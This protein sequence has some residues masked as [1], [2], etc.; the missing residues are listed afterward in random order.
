MLMLR[1]KQDNTSAASLDSHHQAHT[2]V[3]RQT[4]RYLPTTP[5]ISPTFL[6]HVVSLQHS[7][8]RMTIM[9]TTTVS[10][11]AVIA[12]PSTCVTDETPLANIEAEP[13]AEATAVTVLEPESHGERDFGHGVDSSTIV[14]GIPTEQPIFSFRF[15][16]T[17]TGNA[18]TVLPTDDHH[19]I[20][21]ITTPETVDLPH[22]FQIQRDNDR[23]TIQVRWMDSSV[24]RLAIFTAL[25][26]CLVE[27]TAVTDGLG[28]F[29]AGIGVLFI[30]I[31]LRKFMNATFVVITHDS[32]ELRARPLNDFMCS[33][34]VRFD[35]SGYEEIRV[36]RTVDTREDRLSVTFELHKWDCRKGTFSILPVYTE[37]M[38]E[39][40][41]VAQEIRR[42]LAPRVPKAT[43]VST[44]VEIV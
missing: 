21:Y 17:L 25:W 9:T 12:F 33:K 31:T 19:D 6:L 26:I 18:I 32:V 23:S 35:K 16:M 3:L 44:N 15:V 36:K 14:V 38:E 40:L 1:R 29:P 7:S 41:F 43:N 5:R 8:T 27:F 39:A 28:L 13:V 30:Y 24:W 22:R 11:D 2:M 20:A 34:I 10:P 37:R 4:S 42:Y